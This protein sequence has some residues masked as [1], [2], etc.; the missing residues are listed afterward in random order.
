MSVSKARDS[1]PESFN[2]NSA[3]PIRILSESLSTANEWQA[4]KDARD[5]LVLLP[6]VMDE[7]IHRGRLVAARGNYLTVE[8]E[9]TT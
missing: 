4:R 3:I 6:A 1:R 7:A 8:R 9:E 2:L 5:L